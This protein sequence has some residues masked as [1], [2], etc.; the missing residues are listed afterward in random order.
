MSAVRQKPPDYHTMTDRP[1]EE[2][3]AGTP[4]PAETRSA[5]DP[6]LVKLHEQESLPGRVWHCFWRCFCFSPEQI[7]QFFH[8]KAPSEQ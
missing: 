3:R 2:L 6:L 8:P 1:P 7:K 4:Q 5:L